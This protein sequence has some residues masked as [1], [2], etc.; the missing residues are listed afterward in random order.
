LAFFGVGRM[1]WTLALALGLGAAAGLCAAVAAPATAAAAPRRVSYTVRKGDTLGKIAKRFR[2]TVAQL[3][4]WNRLKSDRIRAGHTLRIAPTSVGG[5]L[6][7]GVQLPPGPGYRLKNPDTNWGTPHTVAVLQEAF[8]LFR[9][10]H[11]DSVDIVVGDLSRRG[12]GYFPPHRSHRTG[13]D[14]DLGLPFRGNRDLRHFGRPGAANLDAEKTL[15]LIECLTMAG[16]VELIV[17]DYRLQRPL[18]QLAELR[19]Y[20]PK[21]ITELFQWPRSRRTRAGIVRHSNGHT[22][23]MHVRI[24]PEPAECTA[25]RVPETVATGAPVPLPADT[26]PADAPNHEAK[27]DPNAI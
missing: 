13:R 16:R 19:G 5:R 3:K 27:P 10:R 22:G 25:P 2:V 24:A 6:K 15:D 20:T 26:P 1:A 14:V 8:R 9:E 12:G 4:Q 21:Q 18:V 23:H 7:D 11:P 17:L